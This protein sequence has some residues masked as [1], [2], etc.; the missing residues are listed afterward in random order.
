MLSRIIQ[1]DSMLF[2][3]GDT[4]ILTVDEKESD[5]G[6]L[7]QFTGILRSDTAYHIQDELDAF[8]SIALP[9]TLD[10]SGVS[11][12]APSVLAALLESQQL[13][14]YFRQGRILLRNIPDSVYREMDETGISELLMIEE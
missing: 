6:I 9:V 7:I 14:D 2:Y 4:L 5:N 13:I 10:L 8:T 11:F 3:D 12:L 1:G